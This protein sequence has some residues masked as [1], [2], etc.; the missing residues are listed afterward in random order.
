MRKGKG[1]GGIGDSASP[2]GGALRGGGKGAGTR[3]ETARRWPLTRDMSGEAGT[4]S[5]PE[6]L[7]QG[8]CLSMGRPLPYGVARAM[9]AVGTKKGGSGDKTGRSPQQ[10]A[11]A[12][13]RG[14]LTVARRR[15]K[16]K[17]TARMAARCE[18]GRDPLG[19]GGKQRLA[20]GR[21]L[22]GAHWGGVLLASSSE[23][24]G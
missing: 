21:S 17:R 5:L 4:S 13:N 23:R 19:R 18:A 14:E 24:W 1:E 2:A 16:K 6:G 8:V 11:P 12:D 7:A 22:T 20:C 15:I 10:G 3:E 9:H